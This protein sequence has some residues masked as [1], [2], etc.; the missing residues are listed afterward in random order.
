MARPTSVWITATALIVLGCA[1]SREDY[2]PETTEAHLAHTSQELAPDMA[3]EL[4]KVCRLPAGSLTG[5]NAIS[6]DAVSK[7]ACAV[8]EAQKR[9]V[10]IGFISNP[11]DPDL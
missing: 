1:S 9:G 10:A 2:R 5:D 11:V 8:E 7:L 3:A 6:D 4:E